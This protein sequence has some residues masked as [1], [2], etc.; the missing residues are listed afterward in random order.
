MRFSRVFSIEVLADKTTIN[1]S[2]A[3]APVLLKTKQSIINNLMK[4]FSH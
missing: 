4:K 2:A 3:P 1:L